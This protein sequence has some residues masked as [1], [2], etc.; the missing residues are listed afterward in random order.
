MGAALVAACALPRRPTPRPPL[1][2]LATPAPP[3]HPGRAAERAPR[4]SSAPGGDRSGAWRRRAS[5]AV[6]QGSPSVKRPLRPGSVEAWAA[7]MQR[8]LAVDGGASLLGVYGLN[9]P[10]VRWLLNKRSDLLALTPGQ[11]ARPRVAY[12]CPMPGCGRPMVFRAGGWTCYAHD[13]PF[14]LAPALVENGPLPPPCLDVLRRLDQPLDWQYDPLARQW[15]VR[16]L[17]LPGRRRRPFRQ[18][19]PQPRPTKGA[20]HGK[21]GGRG[22]R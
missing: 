13:R 12:R 14:R 1:G 8:A 15:T 22:T 6:C 19:G 11:A 10:L 7:E 4:R 20:A 3:C 17:A 5:D 18:A 9:S 2:R 21:P 16:E